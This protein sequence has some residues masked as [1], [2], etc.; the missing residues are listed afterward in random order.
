LETLYFE[1]I[2]LSRS[3]FDKIPGNAML[4]HIKF[5][6][7]DLALDAL[8]PLKGV[9]FLESIFF[10]GDDSSAPVLHA[11]VANQDERIQSS[12]KVLQVK[13]VGSN[14][15][16]KHGNWIKSIPKVFP[17]LERLEFGSLRGINKED[18]KAIFKLGKLE[19][20]GLPEC[21]VYDEA[22]DV[23]LAQSAFPA[24]YSMYIHKLKL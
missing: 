14:D 18:I 5:V 6:H 10:V 21:E 16:P 15:K 23:D 8:T 11:Y 4:K 2:R 1:N 17:S 24:F 20:L 12:L 19:Y 9:P 3:A 13:L 7:C 22:F